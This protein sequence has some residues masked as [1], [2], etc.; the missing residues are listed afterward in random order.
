MAEETV[1]ENEQV[2]YA[3]LVRGTSYAYKE[4]TFTKGEWKKVPEEVA[5]YLQETAKDPVT[6][7]DGQGTRQGQSL[8]KFVFGVGTNSLNPDE[9]AAEQGAGA[10]RSRKKTA[11]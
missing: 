11:A 4:H 5:M 9:Y 3:K 8:S 2:T 6:I 1:N 7:T 10:P